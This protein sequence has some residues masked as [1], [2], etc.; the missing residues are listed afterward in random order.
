MRRPHA[1]PIRLL[2][3]ATALT[4]S[5]SCS[6]P[7]AKMGGSPGSRLGDSET[8]RVAYLVQCRGCRVF[9][10][11][12]EAAAEVDG[13]WTETVRV[14]RS[15]VGMVT[16][17]ATPSSGTGYVSRAYIEV[18]GT[19]VAEARRTAA[20]RMGDITLSAPLAPRDPSGTTTR[21]NVPGGWGN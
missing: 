13:Q 14:D 6:V 4:V 3:L 1:C 9:A 16:L 11:G 2:L 18:E 5:S 19:I 21:P 15:T 10:T 8:Y 7:R 17:T 20:D 12:S